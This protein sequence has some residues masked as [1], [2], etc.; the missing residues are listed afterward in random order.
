MTAERVTNTRS[1]ADDF[2]RRDPAAQQEITQIFGGFYS[3]AY[4]KDTLARLL[5]KYAREY[6]GKDG[7]KL[8]FS[9]Q[10]KEAIKDFDDAMASACDVIWKVQ[11]L[12]MDH[13]ALL[14]MIAGFDEPALHE[15]RERSEAFSD[16]I[17]RSGEDMGGRPP[18][19]LPFEILIKQIATMYE[20]ANGHSAI[21]AVHHRADREDAYFGGF[22]RLAE[23]VERAAAKATNRN[24][25]SNV[26]L[27][28]MLK[29][30]LGGPPKTS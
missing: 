17:A 20:Q 12:D 6:A 8:K 14:L 22:F 25:K 4:L 2:D 19:N 11:H 18:E 9:K 29:R 27:G 3:D 7:A 5:R 21:E 24:V 28:T 30:V 26:A 10:E 1:L 13:L 16:A 23:L 15:L